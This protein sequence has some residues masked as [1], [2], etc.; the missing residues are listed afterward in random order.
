M[1]VA[2]ARR[3]GAAGVELSHLTD[4][5]QVDEILDPGAL[6]LIV[7]KGAGVSVELLG[8]VLLERNDRQ[9]QRRHL[10]ELQ[11][12]RTEKRLRMDRRRFTEG[13]VDRELLEA[14]A[15]RSARTV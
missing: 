8:N 1:T 9:L 7:T 15:C 10:S 4:Q 5:H 12:I 3:S 6:P 11:R 2:A 13:N 14:A